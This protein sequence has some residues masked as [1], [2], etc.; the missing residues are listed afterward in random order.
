MVAG[1]GFCVTMETMSWKVRWPA[2][3]ISRSVTRL[4]PSSYV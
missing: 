1:E 4:S 3:V 2:R